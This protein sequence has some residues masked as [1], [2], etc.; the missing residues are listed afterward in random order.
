MK[1]AAYLARVLAIILMIWAVP[2]Y[3]LNARSHHYD[4]RAMGRNP[5]DSSWV[6]EVEKDEQG[7]R[8][9][10][11]VGIAALVALISSVVMFSQL[12]KEKPEI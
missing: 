8:R 1:A 9:D 6:C 7:E 4:L 2:D 3:A 10:G 5:A 11:A 12:K